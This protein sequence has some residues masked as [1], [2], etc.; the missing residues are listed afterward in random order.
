MLPN[1]LVNLFTNTTEVPA[2]YIV[3]QLNDKIAPYD[4]GIIYGQPLASLLEEKKYGTVAGGGTVKEELG[5]ILFCDV[6]IELANEQTGYDVIQIIIDNLEACGAPKGS[7]IIIDETQEE[8]PFGKME[9]IAVYLDAENLQQNS[10]NQNDIDFIQQELYKLTGAKQDTDRYWKDE[11]TTALYFYGASFE[12]MKNNSKHFIDTYSL[13][14]KA[15]I[16]QIA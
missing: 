1:L 16:V 8:I 12:K 4:K 10:Y 11:T 15:R 2:K 7:K 5:E 14:H 3:A 9:G 13:C 6:Q